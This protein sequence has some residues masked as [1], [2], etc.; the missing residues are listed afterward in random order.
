MVEVSIVSGNSVVHIWPVFRIK[1]TYTQKMNLILQ[2]H[3]HI[4]VYLHLCHQHLLRSSDFSHPLLSGWPSYRPE[5]ARFGVKLFHSL[6]NL[7]VTRDIYIYMHIHLYIHTF[8]YVYV[9]LGS[10]MGLM[11]SCH[12]HCHYV[13][14]SYIANGYDFIAEIQL[15][16]F[17]SCCVL[18]DLP[19]PKLRI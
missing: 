10:V 18:L 4:R 1:F 8:T 17:F 12:G 3:P 13:C 14:L 7:T 9:W 2:Y 11:S 19:S 15:V 5:A 16:F 6:R